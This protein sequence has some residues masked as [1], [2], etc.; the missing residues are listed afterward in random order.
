MS[1]TVFGRAVNHIS[2]CLFLTV[3][4][5]AVNSSPGSAEQV[6]T[7]VVDGRI[8]ILESD[9]TWRFKDGARNA[10][11]DSCENIHGLEIC[12]NGSVWR[13]RNLGGS[14]S[15]GYVNANKYFFGVIHE[16]SGSKDGYTYN[17]LQ[18][19]ILSNA[20]K[21]SGV[22]LRQVPVLNVTDE[23]PDFPGFRSITYN[24]KIKGTPFIFHNFF[25]IYDDK[26]F[27]IVFWALGN[28]MTEDF[29]NT[30]DNVMEKIKAK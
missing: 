11:K 1:R 28:K 10:A 12:L 30:I 21:A 18:E 16:S 14:F 20:A 6:G 3:F 17:F 13:K 9:G 27:Q 23:V 8:V 29:Q 2:L 7:A 22:D 24:P 5:T 26:S 19:A 4:L 25:K 15:T